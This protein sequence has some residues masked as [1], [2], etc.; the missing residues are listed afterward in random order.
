M[1]TY[2]D[3]NVFLYAVLYDDARSMRCRKALEAIVEGRM[4]AVTSMLTWDEFS[5]VVERILGRELA[6][7]QEDRFLRFPRLDFL[8]CSMNVLVQAQRLRADTTLGAR[9]CL[10]AATALLAGATTFLSED[11]DFDAVPGLTRQPA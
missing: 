10:H 8:P 11:T 4:E 9:D 3:A 5:H 6:L 2:V 1:R 7:K